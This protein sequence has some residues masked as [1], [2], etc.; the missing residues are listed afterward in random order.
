MV[1]TI[2]VHACAGAGISI[3]D[4]AC[5][6]IEKMECSKGRADIVFNA[7]D[8]SEANFKDTQFLQEVVNLH[9]ISSVSLDNG[10]LDGSGGVR[11]HAVESISKGTREY[12]DANK[13]AVPKKGEIH[14][15]VAS[16]SGGTGNMIAT[17]LLSNFIAKEIPVI[18]VFIGDSS[19]AKYAENTRKTLLTIN[20]LSQK[21]ERATTIRYLIN[22]YTRFKNVQQAITHNN[23]EIVILLDFLSIFNGDVKDLDFQDLT[24]LINPKVK[25]FSI[26]KGVY[27]LISKVGGASSAENLA[28][29]LL[30][31]V[32]RTIVQN[33]EE[34]VPLEIMHSK[35]GTIENEELKDNVQA[36]YEDA[37]LTLTLAAGG[38]QEEID[39]L[40]EI[41]SKIKNSLEETKN[42]LSISSKEIAEDNGTVL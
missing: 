20:N 32:N 24:N 22:D 17:E 13:Y 38:L 40:L 42:L 15:V 23:S 31:I 3:A 2:V 16:A 27:S 4:K 1:K 36:T 19:N 14:F 28:N 29:N 12:L 35:I 7:L 25:D 8:T 30:P 6:F 33:F 41:E 5:E 39:R 34:Y 18:C 9:K 21:S 37:N 11:A 26:P 10:I